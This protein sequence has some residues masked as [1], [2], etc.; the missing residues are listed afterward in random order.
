MLNLEIT[1]I[2]KEPPKV[3]HSSDLED[4]LTMQYS[5]STVR[6]TFKQ[7]LSQ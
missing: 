1:V 5:K 4:E 7:I 6:A 3:E 2:V